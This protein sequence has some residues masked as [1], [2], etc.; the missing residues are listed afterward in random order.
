MEALVDR[1]RDGRPQEDPLAVHCFCVYSES[2]LLGDLLG[3]RKVI[4]LS[5]RLILGFFFA[6]IH[7]VS[8]LSRV[9]FY[10]VVFYYIVSEMTYTV[11][12]GTLNSTIPYHTIPY[13]ILL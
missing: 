7:C 4:F 10:V 5:Y 2:A 8:Y 12:S 1:D 11:S 6:C 3:L 13:C 9:S